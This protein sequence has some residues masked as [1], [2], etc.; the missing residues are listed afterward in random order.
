MVVTEDFTVLLVAGL[1]QGYRPLQVSHR[2]VAQC[3]VVEAA[4]GVR[5]AVAEDFTVLL[6]AV[7]VQG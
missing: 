1:V 6:V 5:V 4:Q 2:L 7:L 3:E